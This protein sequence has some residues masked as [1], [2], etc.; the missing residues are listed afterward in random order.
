MMNN[1]VATYQV[2]YPL[3]ELDKYYGAFQVT[4][5]TNTLIPA[6]LTESDI[7]ATHLISLDTDEGNVFRSFALDTLLEAKKHA[8]FNTISHEQSFSMLGQQLTLKLQPS[9]EFM[10]DNLSPIPKF[11]LVIGVLMSFLIAYALIMRVK[12]RQAYQLS[13]ANRSAPTLPWAPE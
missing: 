1:S 10:E 13:E 2:L 6:Y 4:F 7:F 8:A 11:I 12:E 3:F 5:L 9:V